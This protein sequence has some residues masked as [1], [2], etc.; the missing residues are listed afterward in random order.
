MGCGALPKMQSTE[1][2][3][4]YQTPSVRAGAPNRL[5]A[6]NDGTTYEPCDAP[7]T[8]ELLSVGIDPASVKDVAVQGGQTA[9]GCV[10]R[11]SDP[12]A[13]D[14][15]VSQAVADS[16]SLA[17]FVANQSTFRWR[18]QLAIGD[19][20]LGVFEMSASDC[21]TYVQVERAG[22]T[23]LVQFTSTPAPPID[24]ICSRAIAFTRAT[25]D[26]MPR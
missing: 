1:S 9:R 24:E 20:K 17:D 23:T 13:R 26:K 25:I 18:P 19:R 3:S 10:W 2:K 15:F 21:G 22:V 6:G 8:E 14:W 11:L 5:N 4:T 16:D 12:T 7:S